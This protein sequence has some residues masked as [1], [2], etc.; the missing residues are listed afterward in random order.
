V[1]ISRSHIQS[2]MDRGSLRKDHILALLDEIDRLK[3]P[4]R[5][6]LYI[7][8]GGRIEPIASPMFSGTPLLFDGMEKAFIGT[9]T[10]ATGDQLAVYAWDKLINETVRQGMTREEAEEWVSFNIAGAWV[11][12]GTPLIYHKKTLRAFNAEMEEP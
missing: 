9:A 8:D 2:M 4:H 11:G 5:Q 7:T 3:Q 1:N 12:P 6:P 10:Q